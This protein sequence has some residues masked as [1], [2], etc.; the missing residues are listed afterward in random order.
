MEGRGDNIFKYLCLVRFLGGEERGGERRGAKSLQKPIFAHL[1]FG[2]E[3]REN[4]SIFI[5][6]TK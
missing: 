3:G 1:Q 2:G 6:F 5:T 4:V